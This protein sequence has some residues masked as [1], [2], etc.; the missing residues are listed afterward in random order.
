MKRFYMICIVIVLCMLAAC[1]F[2]GEPAA[3]TPAPTAK[4]EREAALLYTGE[5]VNLY[6]G[7][8]ENGLGICIEEL[9]REDEV[10]LYQA[11]PGTTGLDS[12]SVSEIHAESDGEEPETHIYIH[13]ID[14]EGK[15]RAICLC[16][17]D[18][19]THY[20]FC[21][22]ASE[23]SVMTQEENLLE[24]FADIMLI[25]YLY[26]DFQSDYAKNYSDDWEPL[27][28][29][30]ILDALY[31][32]YGDAFPPYLRGEG[33][34]YDER[35]HLAFVTQE[36]LDGFFRCTV[37]RPNFVPDRMYID[38]EVPELLPGQVPMWP[39]DWVAWAHISEAV[40]IS[41]GEYLLYG[42]AQE[43]NTGF[44]PQ[45]VI[46]HVIAVDGYLGWCVVD[47][48]LIDRSID[49]EKTT[50]KFVPAP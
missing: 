32:N 10:I 23:T 28:Q 11:L 2:F 26:E 3:K 35:Y 49:M 38:E 17:Y 1:K 18:Y 29:R 33:E 8:T 21:Y 40:P 48:E 24:S 45:G 13:Y 19:A 39:T 41:D 44:Y 4:D 22:P 7:R 12:L 30:R 16:R 5:R 34:T 42:Y 31:I 50:A 20:V 9:N 43:G 25:G 36:E 6:Y 47:T 37:N 14:T 27:C 15:T 46:C